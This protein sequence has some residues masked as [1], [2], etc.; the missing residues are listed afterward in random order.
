MN[1][2]FIFAN[3][4]CK[5]MAKASDISNGNFIMHN[6]ELCQITEWM[7]R[8]PGNLRAFYQGKM[9]VLRTGKSVEN[10]FRPDEEVKIV[11]VEDRDLQYLYKDGNAI[12]CMDNTSYEQ[13][14]V[15]ESLFGSGLQFM[16]EGD[17]VSVYFAE[18]A[19]VSA[20]PPKSVE[21]EVTYTEPGVKG[22]TVSGGATKPAR[23]ETGYEIQVPLF[24]EIDEVLKIDTR[25]GK[26][27]SRAND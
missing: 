5:Q 16:K 9:K 7:H 6:N 26:Y 1:P 4:K 14:Y 8:T 17:M 22:D 19:P 18:E 2:F 11:R 25:S 27:I 10:R 12:V 3:L 23:L 24:I 15:D 20:R 13:F 21:L